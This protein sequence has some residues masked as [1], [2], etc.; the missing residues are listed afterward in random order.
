MDLS[1]L[2]FLDSSGLATLIEA[3]K[4]AGE[5][6]WK[7]NVLNAGGAVKKIF[8]ITQMQSLMEYYQ[9]SGASGR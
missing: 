9:R 6:G 1:R 4:R 8:E 5:G 2:S 7:M 3:A